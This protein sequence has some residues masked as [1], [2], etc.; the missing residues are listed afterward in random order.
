MK[1]ISNNRFVNYCLIAATGLFAILL[2][3]S[4]IM[5]LTNPPIEQNPYY[6]ET[7]DTEVERK[8]QINIL[9]ACGQKGL[10]NKFKQFLKE[11]GYDVV[12]IGNNATN[13]DKTVVI[14]R[15]GDI[16]TSMEVAKILGVNSEYVTSDINTELS[17]STTIIIGQDFFQLKP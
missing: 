7:N 14:D 16:E 17:L 4:L 1:L 11:N 9:N 5:R 10:A 13:F 12:E 15:I 8:V 3:A 6:T 2:I